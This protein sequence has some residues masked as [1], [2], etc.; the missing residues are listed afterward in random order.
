MRWGRGG[1]KGRRN[2]GVMLLLIRAGSFGVGRSPGA[3]T[4]RDLQVIC[5]SRWVPRLVYM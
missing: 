4:G 1:P 5:V 2:S 3:A